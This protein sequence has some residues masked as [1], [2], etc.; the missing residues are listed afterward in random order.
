MLVLGTI[1]DVQRSAGFPVVARAVDDAEPA[2]G[3]D[4]DRLLTVHVL[5]GAPAR[6]DLRFHQSGALRRE[7][8]GLADDHRDARILRG[9]DPGNVAAA[10]DDRSVADRRLEPSAFA[11]PLAVEIGHRAMVWRDVRVSRPR[12]Q[13]GAPFR[14]TPERPRDTPRC[15]SREA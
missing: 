4:V 15:R 10:R 6:G 1:W 9:L 13:P 5:A 7:A 12:L 8:V 2:A 3:E 11:Q 14:R